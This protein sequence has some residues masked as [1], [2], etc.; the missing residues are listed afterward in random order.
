MYKR[1]SAARVLRVSGLAAY[2]LV[3]SLSTGGVVSPIGVL[4]LVLVLWFSVYRFRHKALTNW[5]L[6]TKMY[7]NLKE[8]LEGVEERMAQEEAQRTAA[9]EHERRV[10][11]EREKRRAEGERRRASGPT[12]DPAV[13]KYAEIIESR[14]RERERSERGSEGR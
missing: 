4:L 5:E 1:F 14:V 12:R 8:T 13:G 6:V 10:R 7:A 11:V 2:L 9:E 3:G